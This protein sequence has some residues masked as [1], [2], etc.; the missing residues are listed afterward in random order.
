LVSPPQ[1]P[2]DHRAQPERTGCTISNEITTTIAPHTLPTPTTEPAFLFRR[3]CIAASVSSP[4]RAALANDLGELITPAAWSTG[5]LN[6]NEQATTKAP[7]AIINS[8]NG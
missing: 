4:S 8:P 5:R 1:T 3:V 7:S 6:F 2:E